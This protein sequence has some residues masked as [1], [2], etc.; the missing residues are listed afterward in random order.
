MESLSNILSANRRKQYSVE[1][2]RYLYAD[3]LQQI[4]I[5]NED[6]GRR[7]AQEEPG[8]S[9]KTALFSLNWSLNLL[10]ERQI[11]PVEQ[12]HRTAQRKRDLSSAFRLL[13]A[14]RSAG[15]EGSNGGAAATRD[16][17][18]VTALAMARNLESSVIDLISGIGEVIVNAEQTSATKS[19]LRSD[20]A[21]ELFCDRK[22]LSLF[23]DI[24]KAKPN[25]S[26]SRSESCFYGVV[27]SP[28]V[29]AQVLHT[30]SVLVSGVR[31]PSALYFLLSQHCINTLIACMLPLTQWT[32]PALEKMLPAYVDLLKNFALQLVGS[33]HLFPFFTVQ[34]GDDVLFPLLS[35][36]IEIGT[37]SYAQS[38]S[39]VHITCLNLMVDIMQISFEPVRS[40]VSCDAETEQQHL[41]DHLCQLLLRRYRKIAN[42]AIGPVVDA[43]RSKAIGGQLA[44]LNDQMDV[45]NDIFCCG[46]TSLNVRLCEALLRRVVSV[47]LKNLLPLKDRHFLIVGVT[48]ADVVPDREAFAQASAFCLSR[49]FHGLEF[50]PFVRMLAVALFHPLSTPLWESSDLLV[51]EEYKLTTALNALVQGKAADSIPN[52]YR[53]ELVKALRGDY[54]DWRV[55][56]SAMVLE[57][58]MK[59][60][61]LDYGTL[62]R[63]EIFPRFKDDNDH[64]VT[65]FEVALESFLGRHHTRVSAVS[66]AAI[67]C[68]TSLATEYVYRSALGATDGG[69]SMLDVAAVFSGSPVWKALMSARSYFFRQTLESQHAIGVSDIFVDL[70]EASVKKHYRRVRTA[71]KNVGSGPAVYAYLISQH[72]CTVRGA[73]PECIIRKFRSVDSNDV[74]VTRFYSQMALHFRAICRILNRVRCQLQNPDT[75]SA[76]LNRMVDLLMTDKAEELSQIFGC[77]LE[78]PAIGTD[79]DLHGRMAFR[80]SSGSSG[81]QELQ[82][83]SKSNGDSDNTERMRTFSDEMIFRPVSDALFIVL[84][85]TDI[86]VVKPFQRKSVNRGTVLCCIPLLNVI[87]AAKDG[88]WLHVAVRHN[89]V[90]FLVKNGNMALCFDSAGTCLIVR[91]YMDRCRQLLRLELLE[92]IKVLFGEKDD[93][94]EGDTTSRSVDNSIPHLQTL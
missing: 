41:A 93:T 30:V 80:F 18:S 8:P 65:S 17:A 70:V 56:T 60:G 90:G 43:V 50:S 37:S 78:K 39:F 1:R 28:A 6:L 33:P 19:S 81:G 22:M 7:G 91:Q 25:S 54:G 74:E 71:I 38:D 31:D 5:A 63:L 73:S 58:V 2:L 26:N 76:S 52:Q 77:L 85:P 87:A 44:G 11:N 67:E 46:I 88:N 12:D 66:I 21:F 62:V 94:V 14:T 75:K 27:W 24:V 79:L 59:S 10:R 13:A 86:Y 51:G 9:T 61:S 84:D 64:L 23:V 89:D 68:A 42:L 34:D 15:K 20:A 49:L 47:L 3:L 35:A 72:G 57:N 29:K 69:N 32:D 92:K 45:L 82:S 55:V 36:T 53:Q 16:D 48:D 83:P 4:D 40:W